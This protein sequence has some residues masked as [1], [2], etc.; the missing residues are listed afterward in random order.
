[1]KKLLSLLQM[2]RPANVFIAAGSV[3]IGPWLSHGVWQHGIGLDGLAMGL[4]AAAG[5]VHNDVLDL[6]IDRYNRPERPLPAGKITQ[7]QALIWTLILLIA[8]LSLGIARD[9]TTSP[10]IPQTLIFAGVAG[11]LFLYNRWLKPVALV[12]NGV[13]AF[14]CALA[15][16]LPLNDAKVWV[17]TSQPNILILLGVFAFWVT[18]LREL[19]KDLEDVTGDKHLLLQ[20]LPL[21]WGEERTRKFLQALVGIS[22]P[23]LWIPIRLGI[24]S[25]HFLTW[26]G[27]LV[28][29]CFILAFQK[30][31]PTQADQVQNQRHQ[32]QKW[33]KRA[34]L[35]GIL[36]FA[37]TQHF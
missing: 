7:S 13:V 21:I 8:A 5:N 32:A 23:A 19:I 17:A 15:V 31:N 34:M 12:G 26:A 4:L 14:L 20:T 33:M 11:L 36:A 30:L 9:L 25:P 22:V 16:I 28:A 29:P 10:Q 6:E 37:F 1:M 27:I 2:T 24:I 3:W 35:A 18:L